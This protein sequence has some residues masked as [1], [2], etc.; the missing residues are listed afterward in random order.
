MSRS[1]DAYNASFLALSATSSDDF[2]NLKT[3]SRD[4]EFLTGMVTDSDIFV[5]GS[6]PDLQKKSTAEEQVFQIAS[7]TKT[8]SAAAFVKMAVDPRY[9][10]FFD[11]KDPLG[12]PIFIFE[13]LIQQHGSENQK[14]YLFELKNKHPHY[15]Q[16]TLRHLLNHS[17][18][19]AETPFFDEFRKDQTLPHHLSDQYSEP[20]IVADG[21]K[22]F[23]YSDANY[24]NLLVVI[25]EAV[26]SEAQSKPIK[27]SEIVK[28]LV[29]APLD[30]KKTFMC[31]EMEYDAVVNKV[32]VKGA[33][34]IKV[35][36]GYDYFNG[37]VTTGQ[38]FNYDEAA[39]GIYSTAQE[40]SKFYQAMLSGKLFD[41]VAQQRFF[42]PKN[43]IPSDLHSYGLGIRRAEHGGVEYFHHGGAG[44]GFYSHVIGQ[45]NIG[46]G[47]DVKVATTLLSY[48]NLT[49]PIATAL[50]RDEKKDAKGNFLSMRSYLAKCM[51]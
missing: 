12:I 45:R 48:E 37:K 6:E 7:I 14:R 13:G 36:Q 51:S 34:E 44:L 17:S 8:F 20:L 10:A 11:A 50:L 3:N 35:A 39:G 29:V 9:A 1:Q 5:A 21:F 33:P 16:I 2:P 22:K 47:G 19:I 15:D 23:H 41:E 27:F 49:R 42:D 28:D 18:G 43:F 46:G 31:D 25:M 38:D 24:N 26:A 40:V 32:S 30:L 4:S